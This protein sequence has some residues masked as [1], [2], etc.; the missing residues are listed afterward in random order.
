MTGSAAAAN[1]G[2][3]ISGTPAGKDAVAG[4]FDGLRHCRHCLSPVGLHPTCRGWIPKENPPQ[5][6]SLG[7][8][9]SLYPRYHPSLTA[10]PP[11]LR[12]QVP[13]HAC[14]VSGAPGRAYSVQ[15]DSLRGDLHARAFPA[16]TTRFPAGLPPTPGSLKVRDLAVPINMNV[17]R[18]SLPLRPYYS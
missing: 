8:M 10:R 16:R 3:I 9:I 17:S 13:L 11:T 18:A 2:S 7:R 14:P 15:P 6:T 12:M 5:Q 4:F 1:A